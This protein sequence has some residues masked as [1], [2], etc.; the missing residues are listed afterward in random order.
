MPTMR[1]TSR[2]AFIRPSPCTFVT[3]NAKRFPLSCPYNQTSPPRPQHHKLARR[4]GETE[5]MPGGVSDNTGG[6][7][8]GAELHVQRGDTSERAVWS[9]CVCEERARRTEGERLTRVVDIPLGIVMI[10]YGSLHTTSWGSHGMQR[11]T[12]RQ[13]VEA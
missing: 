12:D 6:A 9:G 2:G 8:G 3:L 1:T 13:Q 11:V 4:R 10:T 7:W 5:Y